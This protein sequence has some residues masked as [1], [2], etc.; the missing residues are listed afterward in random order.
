MV[1]EVPKAAPGLED[2]SIVCEF[3]DVFFPELMTMPSEREI[4]FVIDIVPK[5]APILKVPYRMAPAELRELKTIALPPR[6][7]GIHDIFHVSALRRYVFDSSHVIDFTPL[8]LGE[9]LKY[10]EK[11]VRILAREMKELRN[12]VIPYIKMQWSHH[13]ERKATW[14]PE[15]VMQE[16]FP[17]LFET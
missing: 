6:L 15:M 4:E 1:A 5:I 17:Y 12:R 8:E 13:E 11:P 16:S 2:I 9:D 14:E 7:A 3:P 10:E